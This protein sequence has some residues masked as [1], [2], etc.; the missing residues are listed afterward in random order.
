MIGERR[1]PT[2]YGKLFLP[3][4]GYGKDMRGRWWVRPVGE[5]MVPVDNKKVV[6]H[7]DGTVTI[8]E[9]INGNGLVL[10]RG[11]WRQK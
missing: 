2:K 11:V 7:Q 4:G 8:F 9:G 10:E 3:E 5:N 6:E 1:F